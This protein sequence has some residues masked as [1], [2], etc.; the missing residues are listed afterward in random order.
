MAQNTVI[1]NGLSSVHQKMSADAG[2][3][4]QCNDRRPFELGSIVSLLRIV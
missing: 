3:I 1:P 2:G 4:A